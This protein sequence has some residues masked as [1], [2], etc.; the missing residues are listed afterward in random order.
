MITAKDAEGAEIPQRKAVVSA[1]QLFSA[2][3][4]LLCSLCVQNNSK[5]KW[6]MASFLCVLLEIVAYEYYKT[7][8]AIFRL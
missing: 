1:I 7:G 2:F 5:D 4:A 3:I 8:K 6:L